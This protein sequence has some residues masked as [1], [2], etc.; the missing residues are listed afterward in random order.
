MPGLPP[1]PQGKLKPISLAAGQFYWCARSYSQG[2]P[3]G[4]I[5]IQSVLGRTVCPTET[6]RGDLRGRAGS[7]LLAALLISPIFQ[8]AVAEPIAHL[9]EVARIV[10]RDKNYSVRA[11]PTE[12]ATNS[13]SLVESFNGCCPRYRSATAPCKTRK[14]NWNNEL[15]NALSELTTTNQELEA[16]S[17]SVSHDLR[18]PLRSHR[19]IQPGSSRKTTATSWIPRPG[20]PSTRATR[21][22]AMSVLIDDMLNLSRVTR[23]EMHRERLDLSAVVRSVAEELANAS[24]GPESEI[25]HRP[26]VLQSKGIRGCCEWRIENL[27]GQRLEIHVQPRAG[28]N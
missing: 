19:R 27:I 25:L 1:S 16:F 11:A 10:S 13:P 17:Y 15:K 12:V 9:A 14:T 24:A 22:P 20:S 6:L 28:T 5:Y 3:T 23:S 7:S 26:R 21:G 4:I 8:R 18:A 2:N